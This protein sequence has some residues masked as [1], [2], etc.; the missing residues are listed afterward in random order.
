MEGNAAHHVD[1]NRLVAA[2]IR[3]QRKRAGLTQEQAAHA[4][5]LSPQHLSK[6]ERCTCS[7]TVSTVVK[8]AACLGVEPAALFEPCDLES[9]VYIYTDI[10]AE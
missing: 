8:L 7:P 6:I 1:Y 2:N 5:D 10:L 3:R 4:A 9:C